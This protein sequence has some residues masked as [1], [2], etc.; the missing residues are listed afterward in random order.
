MKKRLKV[1]NDLIFQKVFGKQDSKDILISLIN[2]ILQPEEECKVEEVNVIEQTKQDDVSEEDYQGKVDAV[3]KTKDGNTFNVQLQLLNRFNTDKRVL[4]N[5]SKTFSE[6]LGI[7]Q[8]IGQLD[9]TI[10]I[11]FLDFDFIEMDNYHTVFHLTEDSNSNYRF[12]DLLEVHFIE[13]SK[14]RKLKPDINKPLE[15]WMLFME[16][17]SSEVLEMITYRDPSISK[18]EKVLELLGMDEEVL[19]QYDLRE[20]SI[21]EEETKFSGVKEEGRKEG[22]QEGVY[23]VAKN[24][25]NSGIDFQTIKKV[26]GLKSEEIANLQSNFN[27]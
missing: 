5:W 11:N 10:S 14:F 22:I 3:A 18:A 24:M 4:Y 15:R 26:T 23:L 8:S 17:T 12:T 20:K 9:K 27:L 1:K 6:N 7:G 19:K 25:L 2:S 21:N 16:P 13:L